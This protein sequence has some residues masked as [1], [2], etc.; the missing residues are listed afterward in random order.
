MTRLARGPEDFMFDAQGHKE[1]ATDLYLVH[2]NCIRTRQN[3]DL[4]TSFCTKWGIPNLSV[5]YRE[6][7]YK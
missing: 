4:M 6:E 5:K 3:Q 2:A 7:D 1:L